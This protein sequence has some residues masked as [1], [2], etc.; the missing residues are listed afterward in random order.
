MRLFTARW[1]QSPLTPAGAQGKGGPPR[2][3]SPGPAGATVL[4]EQ[5]SF[6]PVPILRSRGPFSSYLNM[7]GVAPSKPAHRLAPNHPRPSRPNA[8]QALV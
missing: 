7:G 6:F 2:L 1:P 5:V 8:Q 4:A 3:L